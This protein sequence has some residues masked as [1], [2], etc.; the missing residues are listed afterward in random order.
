MLNTL[1]TYASPLLRYDVVVRTLLHVLR[2]VYWPFDDLLK[3]VEKSPGLPVPDPTSPYWTQP[4][5]PI[6]QRNS[7]S[8]GKRLP[9]NADIVII[10]SG[11]TGTSFARTV[12]DHGNG[13]DVHG[14]LLHIVMLEARD[15]CSGATG[16]CVSTHLDLAIRD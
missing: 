2:W 1:L 7:S 10:G 6:A 3:R 14:K 12:L 13:N 9:E 4:P 11:I 5:S 8:E 15:A 16:R